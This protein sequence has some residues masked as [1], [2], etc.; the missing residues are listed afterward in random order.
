MGRAGRRERGGR[1]GRRRREGAALS[2]RRGALAQRTLHSR[3]ERRSRTE[4]L[5][6]AYT[7]N[8]P[9][10]RGEPIIFVDIALPLRRARTVLVALV[11]DGDAQLWIRQVDAS[12]K[13]TVTLVVYVDIELRLGEPRID[14]QESAPCLWP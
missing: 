8:A 10:R 7:N 5:V 6:S 9:S 1:S 12:N 2:V 3:H 11:F 4:H 13:L 14:E